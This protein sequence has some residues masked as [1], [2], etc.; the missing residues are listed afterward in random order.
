MALSNRTIEILLKVNDKATKTVRRLQKSF[1]I[2]GKVAKRALKGISKTFGF[3]LRKIKSVAK[4]IAV[5]TTAA[6]AGFFALAK[7]IVSTA[8]QFETYNATLKV[9]MGS[10]KK[11]TKAM[12][13]LRE[14]AKKSPY[15]IDKLTEAFVKLTA[16][17]IEP[18][19]VMT[20]L[21]DT[22][23]AMGRDIEAAVLALANAQTGEFETLKAFGITA[24]ELTRKNAKALGA[25]L[26]D[27]GRTALT[28]TDSIGK[29]QIKIID[30]T[31]RAIITSTIMSI[32]NEKYEGAQ[33]ERVATF[34]GLTSNIADAWIQFKNAVGKALLPHINKWLDVLLKKLEVW[35]EDG[36]LKGWGDMIAGVLNNTVAWLAGFVASFK[37]AFEKIGMNFFGFQSDIEGSEEAGR[38]F[39]EKMQ[40]IFKKIKKVIT[41]WWVV[42]VKPIW[43]K[44]VTAMKNEKFWAEVKLNLEKVGD[45][46]VT[47]ANAIKNVHRWWQKVASLKVTSDPFKMGQGI[48]KITHGKPV[49]NERDEENTPENKNQNKGK[50]FGQSLFDQATGKASGGGV[51]GNKP[52]LVGE[53]GAE[54]FTPSTAGRVTANDQIGGGQTVNIFT[55]ATAHGINNALGSRMDVA[56]RGQ[57]IGLRVSHG[58]GQGQFS[59]AS[60]LRTRGAW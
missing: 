16:Y 52:I 36:T 51:Y 4:G 28:F 25:T 31:N 3:L 40:E 14:M 11:A 13:W 59:N 29:Q 48:Y 9:V 46:F 32:W 38:K 44:F 17:G 37:E 21:G 20:T 60:G 26:E 22:A 50:R 42:G 23:S 30:R 15:T 57:R 12:G 58:L 19:K 53:R 8:A 54:I 1:V 6:A 47:L 27:V 35:A 39:G 41:E 10:Q 18:T 34:V 49:E 43:D 45:A 5:A 7:S 33:K 56:K 55:N 2:L 24:V